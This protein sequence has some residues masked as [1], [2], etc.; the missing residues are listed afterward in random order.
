MIWLVSAILAVV[1]IV[2]TSRKIRLMYLVFMLT[3]FAYN[4]GGSLN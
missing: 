3:Y 2:L 4:L 1:M